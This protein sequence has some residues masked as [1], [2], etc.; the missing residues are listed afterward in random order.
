V[1]CADD[2][3]LDLP[4]AVIEMVARYRRMRAEQGVGWG[5]DAFPDMFRWARF[6]RLGAAFDAMA[7]SGDWAGAVRAAVGDE[8]PAGVALVTVAADG[9]LVTRTG[10]PRPVVAGA[11]VP[12][13]VVLDAAA[14]VVVTVDG[15]DVPVPA[16]GA[17]LRTVDATAAAI[18]VACGEARTTVRATVGVPAAILRL[19]CPDGARW[20]VTDVTGGAWF[21]EGVPAK[22]DADDRPLFHTGPGTTEVAVPA[23]PTHVVAARGLEFERLEIDLDVRETVTVDYRPE[24]RFDPEA[25]GWYGGDLHVHLNYSGD[26]VL[27]PADARRM[28]RGEGL[29]LLH[30]A[31]GNLGGALVY[32]RELL[33]ATAGTD[34]WPGARA[35]LEFRNDLLG[36]VHGLGLTGVPPLLQTGHDGTDHPWDWPPNSVACTDMQDLGAVTTYAHPVFAPDGDGPDE[37]FRPFRMVEAR[38]LVADAAL[39]VVDAIELASC[40]DDRGALVLYHHLLSCG[41]R[42]AAVAGTDAFLS[43]ARG[44]APASNPPGWCRVYAQLGDA[45][46]TVDA[47]TAAVRAG[48]TLVTNGPWLALEVD[49]AGPG[50]VLDRRRGDRVTVSART[51]GSGV[52]R[53]VLHGP[54]GELASGPDRLECEVAVDGG[55]WLAASAHGGIDPYTPGAPVFAHTTPVYVDVGGVRVGRRASALWC[56]RLLDGLVELAAEQGRFDPDDRDRQLGDLLAVVNRAREFYRAVGE[57][58]AAS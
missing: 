57:R 36:H 15:E 47:F 48:R 54:D 30:L 31:A 33:E 58:S 21:A 51:V 26:H 44:P 25:D 7:T 40:F 27:E 11:T 55:L 24:R 41:L 9:R 10:P 49:G 43:F 3:V 17:G 23:G 34:L 5:E 14:D 18:E 52:E 2:D 22:W 42:L 46:L 35:G 1:C 53:L 29:A 16:G 37:L 12:I 38:E 50:T 13:D 20:S 19:T 39:G 28:Q 8:V 56:L 32:D 6:S 45:L 4:P